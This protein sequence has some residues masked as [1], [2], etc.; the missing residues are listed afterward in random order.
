VFD[1]AASEL[2]EMHLKAMLGADW[3][4]GNFDEYNEKKEELVFN[5][6]KLATHIIATCQTKGPYTTNRERR[7]GI[8][9]MDDGQL[10]VNSKTLWRPDGC[11]LK[12]GI[13]ENHVYPVSRDIGFSLT[14]EPASKV[15]IERVLTSFRSLQW[16]TPFSGEMLLGW[17]GISILA[18]AV[19]RRPHVLL[20]G[21]AGCG[22][23]TMLEQ[24]RWLLGDMMASCT[25]GQTLM[26]LNQLVQEQP[27]RAIGIDEFEADPRN[28][29]C[30][31]TLEAAR[32][33]YSLQEGDEGIVRGT[34]G[35]NAKC[36]RLASPFIAAGIS[37]GKMEPADRSRWVVLESRKLEAGGRG[38]E[39]LMT[40]DEASALGKR[41]CRL[42][43]DR[44]NVFQETAK[45]VRHVIVT[46]GG[47]GRI[48]DTVGTLLAAYWAFI[49]DRPAN[50]A[51]ASKLVTEVGL[52]ERIAVSEANDEKECL[53][54]LMTRVLPFRIQS[55][56]YV[57]NRNLAVGEAVQLVASDPTGQL[58]ITNR[59]AQFGMRVAFTKGKWFMYV[60]NSPMHTELRKLFAGTKWAQGGWGMLLRRLPGGL[61][62]TQ[63]VGS[64]G[65]QKVTIFDL[66]EALRP[67]NDA[68]MLLA[69]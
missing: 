20:T 47:D 4:S 54:A 48:S 2:K 46:S 67:A 19:K 16:I 55:G 64:Q 45:T 35:G 3:C 39:K 53:E 14:T 44:W 6:K 8:W 7:A 60:V 34:P 41:L 43:V 17:V 25:G 51:D 68:E 32:S 26:G 5:F 10:I 21:P 31:Q 69:A 38:L 49:S 28:D 18:A 33:S 40:E 24:V 27:S 56:I 59:L 9:K 30:R 42:F 15:D 37:P 11:S 1:L 22:K 62:S 12:H 57:L 65:A 63:R 66:P 52:D 36:Y 29:K 58:D 23:S 50:I 13:I 61:E